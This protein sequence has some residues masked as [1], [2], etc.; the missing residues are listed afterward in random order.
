MPV[1]F[2][3]YRTS[4]L[5]LDS[6]IVVS[7]KITH[8]IKWIAPY[9]EKTA[10]AIT[11]KCL[12]GKFVLHVGKQEYAINPGEG[13]TIDSI[14]K[15]YDLFVTRY[16]R[17]K[18]CWF[19]KDYNYINPIYCEEKYDYSY[20][21]S[22]RC[23][24]TNNEIKSFVVSDLSKNKVFELVIQKDCKPLIRYTSDSPSGLQI[25]YE[26][27]YGITQTFDVPSEINVD[28]FVHAF[29]QTFV[30]LRP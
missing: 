18:K 30:L 27:V 8:K 7:D 9:I 14:I 28:D 3:A 25:E 2:H 29:Y 10:D 13:E 1:E 11:Y 4:Y 16:V 23:K 22:I 26:D 20:E 19:A 5:S 12:E 6:V 17:H 21:I 24:R 15:E